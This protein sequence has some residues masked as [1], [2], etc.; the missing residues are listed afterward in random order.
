MY[1]TNILGKITILTMLLSVL[2][3]VLALPVR[4]SPWQG[5]EPEQHSTTQTADVDGEGRNS[6]ADEWVVRLPLLY[7]SFSGPCVPASEALRVLPPLGQDS[8]GRDLL[9]QSLLPYLTVQVDVGKAEL[10][11]RGDDGMSTYRFTGSTWEPVPVIY[12]PF[13]ND[14][15]WWDAE[16]Y[17]TIH[18]GDVDG[19]TAFTDTIQLEDLTYQV[20]WQ[21]DSTEIGR[22]FPVRFVVSGMELGLVS[23]TP[24]TE[25]TVLIRFRIDR[26]ARIRARVLHGEGYSAAQ[27]VEALLAEFNCDTIAILA[28]EGYGGAEVGR[29]LRDLFG[30]DALAAAQKMRDVGFSAVDAAWA[31]K[32]AFGEDIGG[33]AVILYQV[34][35]PIEDVIA[36]LKEVYGADGNMAGLVLRFELEVDATAAARALWRAGY[37]MEEINSVMTVIYEMDDPC[38]LDLLYRDAGIPPNEVPFFRIVKRFAPVLGFDSDW[39]DHGLPM[40]AQVYFET[41][42]HPELDAYGKIFWTTPTPDDGPC[43]EPGVVPVCTWGECDCGMHNNNFQSL[44]DGQVPTYFQYSC[45]EEGRLRIVYWWFYGFQP[46][47]NPTPG[48]KSGS[49]HGDWEHILVTTSPDRE[50]VDAVTYYFHSFW[51]TRQNFYKVD[52][53]PRVFVGKLGHGSYVSNDD[54]SCWMQGTPHHCCEYADCR[55]PAGD[56]WW[57]TNLN[58]VSLSGNSEPWMLADRIGSDYDGH[59]IAQWLWGPRITGTDACSTHPTIHHL[60]TWDIASCNSG[61]CGT[62]ECKGLCYLIDPWPPW[63]CHGFFSF[64]EGWP[65][66]N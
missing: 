32:A 18:S 62:W 55:N 7:H 48:S 5:S 3:G 28:E 25:G 30:L 15:G 42:L 47:C 37:T 53:H 49:H 64:N 40:S 41:M 1:R 16:N 66:D 59:E 17:A 35:Y 22:M 58:L 12:G 2:A 23:Y 34:G 60:P 56:T 13:S 61:G 19:G 8:K 14:E 27:V 54:P 21:I 39:P 46:A 6:T 50:S 9:D 52:E 26:N 44:T 31:L 11:G 63:I 20:D 57:D 29:V 10:L 4:S 43:G 65:W 51:Y 36:A 33:A 38:E 24:D 45:N